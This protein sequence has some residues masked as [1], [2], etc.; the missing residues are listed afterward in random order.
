MLKFG[1]RRRGPGL[2]YFGVKSGTVRTGLSSIQGMIVLALL[3]RPEMTRLDLA[4]VVW[5]DPNTMPDVWDATLRSHV[6]TLNKR[7]ARHGHRVTSSN[8]IYRLVE[9]VPQ[10]MAA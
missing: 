5:P 10:R 9:T 3:G 1:Y 7:I 6:C 8:T 2:I 4:E